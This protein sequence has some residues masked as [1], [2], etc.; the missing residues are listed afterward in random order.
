MWQVAVNNGVIVLGTQ[1][2]SIIRWSYEDSM[3]EE[4]QL[5]KRPE[6][7]LHQLFLD[8][9]GTHLLVSLRSGDNYYLHKRNPRPKKLVKLQGMV[10]ESVAFDRQNC[11]ETNTKS[12]LVG[13]DSGAIYEVALD[14][15]GKE[16]LCNLVYQLDEA[17][18]VSAMYFEIMG[19]SETDARIFVLLA[20]G[21]PT[22]LYQFLGGPTFQQMFQTYKETG[23]V[24]L[25]ELPGGL[26][27]T[28]LY[29]FNKHSTGRTQTFALLCEP[30]IYHGGLLFTAN[31]SATDNAITE[32]H[33][34][35]FSQTGFDTPIS[36]GITEFH[37]VLLGD[38]RMQV[39]SRLNSS[40]VQELPLSD[41]RRYGKPLGI[42]RDLTKNTMW[43]YTDCHIFQMMITDET[44][45]VWKIYLEKA[46]AG[47]DKLFDKAYT[48]APD[49]AE[50]ATVHE[51]QAKLYLERGELKRAAQYFAKTPTP[52]EDVVLKLLQSSG[53]TA[54]NAAAS[55]EGSV[56]TLTAGFAVTSELELEALQVYLDERVRNLPAADKSQ[57]TML[58][59][60]LLEILLHRLEMAEASPFP[61]SVSLHDLHAFLRAFRSSLDPA[62]TYSMLGAH[63]RRDSILIYA[64]AIADYAVVV[65]SLVTDGNLVEAIDALA[66][67]PFEKIEALLYKYAPILMEQEPKRTT[68][69]LTRLPPLDATRI[70]PA[71]LRYAQALEA[72][73]AKLN[74][75]QQQGGNG[76]VPRISYQSKL[77]NKGTSAQS[78]LP[79][80]PLE[81]DGTG[82]R[83]NYAV[84]YLE[85]CLR[86]RRQHEQTFV[87]TLLWLR[88]KF[89]DD[90]TALLAMLEE[91]EYRGL[92]DYSFAFRI[93]KQHNCVRTCVQLY[94][95]QGFWEEA[96]DL[97]LTVSWDLAKETAR[98]PHDSGVQKKLWLRIALRLIGQKDVSAALRLLQESDNAL[99][100]EDL[101][102]FLPDFTQ[103]DNFKDEI[104]RTL[105]A[106]GNRIESLQTEMEE[107][108]ERC[109]LPTSIALCARCGL[110]SFAH[111]LLCLRCSAAGLDKELQSMKQRAYG[112]S[113]SARCDCCSDG[114]FS[115]QVCWH[116]AS[117]C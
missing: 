8:P 64:T 113:G 35:H 74:N 39:V 90:E 77:K 42:L 25:Q 44:R 14:S 60:W 79:Q 6:D 41:Q 45:H 3:P 47:E 117:V 83:V 31:Q 37:F 58:C 15:T 66:E 2:S 50:R 56:R 10:I 33:L 40:V 63:G 71:L 105:E 93:C 115:R 19:Q 29:C 92:I 38:D 20:T 65:S 84:V 107:L 91:P 1:D 100:I 76:S 114:L 57:K 88:A 108:T 62:T 18:A 13:T 103:L 82:R 69:L 94:T 55:A 27:H 23:E 87:H 52:F 101:L 24:S 61:A 85:H 111:S 89:D 30:G 12:F 36:M 78:G 16:R 32:A 21:R 86:R 59:T 46:L 95:L 54:A 99:Q 11:T 104:C 4:I 22:R 67:A 80:S 26:D 28:E 68:E 81:D 9:T 72:S 73:R 53:K 49:K 70:M 98:K 106:Y 75:K 48:Y 17:I 51:A 112:M 109:V 96:V 102:P 34:L 97:A 5:P 7:Q 110:R 116:L 43:L